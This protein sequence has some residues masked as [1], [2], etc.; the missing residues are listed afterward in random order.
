M[1]GPFN[2]TKAVDY[3]DEELFNYWVDLPDIGFKDVIKPTSEVPMIILGSKGSGKT[4]IMKHFS[5][6]MQSFRHSAD[7]IGGIQNDGYI[8]TYLRCSGLNGYRF[9]GRGESNQTWETFF[10]YYL[11]LWLGQLLLNNIIKCM[12]LSQIEIIEEKIVNQ[13][14][15]LF[16]V[17]LDNK[18]IQTIQDLKSFLNTSQKEVDFAINNRALTKRSISESVK[19]LVTPGKLIFGIPRIFEKSVK[20]FQSLKFLYLLDE[21]ENFTDSQQK[22][23]N[24]LIRERENPVCFK[25]GSRRYGLRTLKTLSAGEEIKRGSEYEEFDIDQIFRKNPSNYRQFIKDICIK[26]LENAHINFNTIQFEKHFEK[27][28]LN[29]LF[30]DIDSRGRLHLKKLISILD[31]SKFKKD[32][33]EIVRNIAF[34]KDILLERTNIMLLYRYWKRGDNLLDASLE[35]K[36]SCLQIFAGEETRNQHSVVLR[37]Y[38]NDLIDSLYRENGLKLKSYTGF[39]NLIRISNGNP[40]HFL[41]IMKHIYRWSEFLGEK[42]FGKNGIISSKCQLFALKDTVDWFIENA[43]VPEDDSNEVFESIERLCDWLRELR[44]SDVPPEC[45]IS[46]FSINSKVLPSRVSKILDHLDKYS[47]IT[48][49]NTG[50]RDKNFNNRN[51]TYQINGLLAFEWE[52]SLARRGVVSISNDES[53]AIFLPD[54][55]SKYKELKNLKLVKYNAP[56]HHQITLP[57]LFEQ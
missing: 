46:T 25:I 37:K 54:Q 14:L 8:G 17:N 30:H 22:Y 53:I 1:S 38:K 28:N 13:I 5:Y 29:Q 10:S 42:I 11:E 23:F 24:T 27:Q 34:K 39:S 20:E 49:I 19:V 41:L 6:T 12:K 3:T 15:E 32:R 57:D 55:D 31:N 51:H 4:H 18:D 2:I 7:V 21:Y 9:K 36:K 16:D 44:Y 35:I 43:K 48:K 47:Y 45:S 40:R 50:R 52:L 56:F 26:R 33:K